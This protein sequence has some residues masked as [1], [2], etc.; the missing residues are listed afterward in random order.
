MRER[1]IGRGNEKNILD[2]CYNSP[3]SEF[4][5][6]YG[7]RRVGKTFL[8]REMFES[9]FTFFAEGILEGDKD[10]QLQNFNKEIAI[11]G[12]ANFEPATN[13]LEAFDNLNELIEISPMPGKKVIFLDEIP[14]IGT[15]GTDFLPAL[16]HF[17][18]RW[19]SPRRDVLLIIC[20]SATSWII[21]N[22][23]G[24]KGGLHNRLTRQIVLQP[25]TL[26][27]CEEFYVSKGVPLTRYQMA[28]S[29]MIFGGIP[30]YINFMDRALSLHQNVDAMYFADGAP[31][32]NEYRFLFRSLFANPERHIKIIESLA[33]KGKGFTRNEI[34]AQT[35]FSNSGRLTD[36]MNELIQC[37][38]VREYLAFGKKE[39]DRLFQLTDP[40]TIFHLRFDKKR[41]AY[42]QNYWIRFNATPA[43]SAWSGFAF[44]R[45]CLL[46][47][48]QIK[49]AMGISGV[50][51]EVSSWRSKTSSPGAQIDIVID[52]NDNVVNLCEV[53]FASDEFKIDKKLAGSLRS[54]R[55]VFVEETGTRK[56]VHTTM[57]T[58]FGLKHNEYS[59]EIL[60]EVTLDELFV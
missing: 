21:D 8:I 4:V 7:R 37:G 13:W 9:H 23:I 2:G 20:G 49:Q 47:L 45:V 29:Y 33:A 36:L 18:N 10:T 58:T 6:V 59:G 34:A 43:H 17:W 40:F 53:K 11:H 30:Y 16:G 38:F 28:E 25:F 27:E 31:L 32:R 57:I 46:H 55:T 5:A 3:E 48:P 12:G 19:A 39:R 54:K 52:R 56:A 41:K 44:E 14:Y 15:A 26:K 24:N 22:I 35:G 50:L 1:I 51:T 60:Q 42:A